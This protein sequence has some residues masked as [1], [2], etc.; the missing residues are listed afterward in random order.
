[1]VHEP[2]IIQ[3]QTR[4]VQNLYHLRDDRTTWKL[5]KVGWVLGCMRRTL[6]L[7]LNVFIQLTI[8]HLRLGGF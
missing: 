1:M 4:K 8:R 7:G 2:E 3:T 6:F 5:R